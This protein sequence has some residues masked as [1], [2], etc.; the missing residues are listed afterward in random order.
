VTADQAFA[1]PGA[2]LAVAAQYSTTSFQT[3]V[4]N[5]SGAERMFPF[6]GR[7]GVRLAAGATYSFF[8]DPATGL[9]MNGFPNE[10]DFNDFSRAVKN[11]VLE[12]LRTPAVIITDAAT[13]DTKVLTLVGGTVGAGDPSYGPNSDL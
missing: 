3:T 11:N 13:Q 12:V 6:L 10:R 9:S 8:G 4:K 5:I 7:R 1:V 2:G